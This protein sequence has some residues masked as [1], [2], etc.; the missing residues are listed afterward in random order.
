MHELAL[1]P[2]V[3]CSTLI[4]AL[5][6]VGLLVPREAKGEIGWRRMARGILGTVLAFIVKLPFLV[7]GG[8]N[9]F[10]LIRLVY[11]DLVMLVPALGLLLLAGEWFRRWRLTIFTRCLA[12]TSLSLAGIGVY[13]TYIELFDLRLETARLL[14]PE[15]RQGSQPVRLAV[16]SDLQTDGVTGY[17]REAVARLMAARPDVILIP[18]DM[19]QGTERAFEAQ[20]PELQALLSRLDAPGGVFLV[21]GNIDVPASR[22]GRFIGGT[23]IRALLNDVESVFIG[24]RRLT[25]GGVEIDYTSPRARAIIARL[26]GG[27]DTGDIRLLLSHRPDVV[28]ELSW[29]S[30]IDLV[31]AGH[32]HGGQGVIP[33]FG[34]PMT[35]TRVPRAVA[36]GG[37]HNPDGRAVYVSR[38]VGH[39]RGQ[40]ARL[41]FLCPPEISLITLESTR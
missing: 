13:A 21:P 39:K 23:R 31:V 3:L 40:A 30:R 14:L 4:D 26:E 32:T 9:P 34:P 33:F 25:I 2:V 24:D 11:V 29:N 17:E 35:G 38:G 20:L 36:A 6:A 10:G 15:Q 16:L 22:V 28:L 18:G 37:L 12:G 41:R 8:L 1:S 5:V 7:V 19:F 27:E